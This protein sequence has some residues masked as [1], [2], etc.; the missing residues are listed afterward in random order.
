M[1]SS[2]LCWGESGKCG[3]NLT[4]E[5]DFVKDVLVISGTGDMYDYLYEEDED[6]PFNNGKMSMRKIII[7]EGVTSIGNYAFAMAS[8]I[9]TEVVLPSTLTRIGEWAFR[10]ARELTT[11][12]ITRH[13]RRNFLLV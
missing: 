3:E 9:L 1:A 12:N 6:C 11:I 5:Y 2:T 8:S 4:Y 7:E 10:D 13:R